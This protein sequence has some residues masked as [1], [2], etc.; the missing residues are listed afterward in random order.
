MTKKRKVWKKFEDFLKKTIPDYILSILIQTG[1]DNT[2]S[3]S[4]LCEKDI[5]IIEEFVDTNL[6]HLIE[7]SGVYKISE[8]FVFLPGHKKL[9]LSLPNQLKVFNDKI[10]V[11]ICDKPPGIENIGVTTDEVELLTESELN[12]L[13]KKLLSKLTASAQ[14][15][16]LKQFTEEELVSSLNA[17]I[18]HSRSLNSKPS[19][20]C[21]VKCTEC[22]KIVPCTWNGYWQTG[23]LETH[24]KNHIKSIESTK[25][26]SPSIN[27]NTSTH[28]LGPAHSVQSEN[29]NNKN[30][31]LEGINQS[32][33][34]NF[35][36]EKELN[37]VLGL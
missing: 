30:N 9:I 7:D 33:C 22:E 17:Y 31:R 27:A 8:K 29:N 32:D 28:G 12:D 15:I 20:R 11:K 19:Y 25:Q 35:D 10:K 37:N 26:L 13:K 36:K 6:K 5:K 34:N 1:L 14:S 3:I 16:G 4:E 2:F 24:L 21:S 23:N 18:N